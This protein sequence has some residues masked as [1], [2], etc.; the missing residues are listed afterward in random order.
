M[1]W[2]LDAMA[3]AASET[4]TSVCAPIQ[5][6]SVRAFQGGPEIDTYLDASRKVLK[7]LGNWSAQQ[8]RTVGAKVDDPQGAFYLFPEFEDIRARLESRGIR[9]AEALCSQMLEST[10]VAV[11]PGTDFGRPH[12]ELSI[13]LAYVDFDGALAIDN[14]QGDL[15]EAWL[16][17]HC[18]RV[19]DGIDRMVSWLR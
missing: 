11:L 13:R 12:G 7:A 18:P 3:T 6:A 10:G 15:D 16:R 1:R 8:L 5:H 4:Y 19:M 17:N 9:T 2:L 14:A